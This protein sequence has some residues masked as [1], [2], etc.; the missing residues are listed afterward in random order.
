MPKEKMAKRLSAKSG[1][2]RAYAQPVARKR[3]V[4]PVV[5]LKDKHYLKDS[6]EI[7]KIRALEAKQEQAREQKGSAAYEFQCGRLIAFNEVISILQQQAGGFG[8]SLK[9][10]S[11][12]DIDPDRD[13]V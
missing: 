7:L 5:N 1:A 11:L 3:T 12:D 6:A 9:E 8:I 4:R 13:I 10:L 2:G